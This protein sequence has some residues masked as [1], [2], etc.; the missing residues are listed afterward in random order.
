M[1]PNDDKKVKCKHCVQVEDPSDGSKLKCKHCLAVN[2]MKH[3]PLRIPCKDVVV[4]D[5]F[6]AELATQMQVAL[7]N[8]KKSNARRAGTRL[9]LAGM[10]RSPF[11]PLSSCSSSAVASPSI[12][13]PFF[14]PSTIQGVQSTLGSLNE[15]NRKDGY[16]VVWRFWYH[17]NL[18]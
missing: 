1:D 9:E 11:A 10:G 2:R 14:L 16:M 13:S 7:D 12:I 18:I 8:I 4:C 6:P 15:K 3:H 17:V 5:K